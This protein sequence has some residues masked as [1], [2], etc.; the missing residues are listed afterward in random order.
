MKNYMDVNDI[1]EGVGVSTSRA[2]KIIRTLN[3]ELKEKG[4]LTIS[5]RVPTK[6]F[7][8]RWYGYRKE[9]KKS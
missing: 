9:E 6:Y 8:E 5:G 7:E 3:E 1:A 2:Y 4:Y